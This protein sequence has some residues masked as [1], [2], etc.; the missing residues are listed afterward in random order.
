MRFKPISRFRYTLSL[1]YLLRTRLGLLKSLVSRRARVSVQDGDLRIGDE[2][3]P[4]LA[5]YQKLENKTYMTRNSLGP[6]DRLTRGR[7]GIN[8]LLSIITLKK[9]TPF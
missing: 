9:D 6:Q 4:T 1:S 2:H 7:K 8:D 3:L 5:Y